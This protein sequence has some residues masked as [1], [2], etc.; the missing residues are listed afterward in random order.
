MFIENK[1]A[2]ITGGA[3]GIGFRY[4]TELLANGLKAVT[5]ADTDDVKGDEAVAIISKDFSSEK[6]LFVKTDVTCKSQLENAFKR[7]VETFGQLDILVNNAGIMVENAWEKML[8]INLTGTIYGCL[9]AMEE[10]FPKYK[11]GD[12]TVIVNISS[13]VGLQGASILP[14]YT[15]SKHAVIGLTTSLGKPDQYE[16][17]RTRIVAI[18][19]GPTDTPLMQD[20]VKKAFNQRYVD[21]TRNLLKNYNMQLQKADIVPKCLVRAIEE[22]GNGSVWVVEDDEIYEVEIPD[23]QQM[24]K[25]DNLTPASF[26]IIMFVDKKVALVTGGASGLGFRYAIEL[27]QNGLRAV[28]L[29]DTDDVKGSEAVSNISKDFGADKVLFVKTDV[30][31]K[32]QLDNAFKRT[33]EKFGNVDIVINNAGVMVEAIWEKMIG[34]NVNGTIYGCI[35][36]MEEYF[37]KY[38]SGKEA[39]IVNIS[40]VA[41]LQGVSVLPFYVATKHAVIG[42]SRSLGTPDQYESS[43]TRVVTIC[44]GA[45]NTP[46]LHDLDKK[47]LND[48]Y[49]DLTMKHPTFDLFPIQQVDI[50]PKCMIKVIEEGANGS[51]WVVEDDEIY[52]VEL[53]NRQDLKKK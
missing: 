33:V 6:V 10:Y 21:L 45:T 30:S 49:L 53:R 15:A 44:P 24:K 43:K 4:A 14:I 34:I 3:S 51:I 52:E 29:A 5:L 38:K 20:L 12:E 35:L 32:E 27:L 25:N 1:V 47:V 40:S 11:S 2:I 46:L 26:F 18:C 23:R 48:R 31:V 9:L 17:T 39:V 16:M 42:L 28:T 8:S 7:T 22:G 50:V 37:P 36:A 13:I 19:P 41:G